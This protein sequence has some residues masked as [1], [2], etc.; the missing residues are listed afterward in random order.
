MSD[1]SW[2]NI[3]EIITTGQLRNL[4]VFIIITGVVNRFLILQHKIKIRSEDVTVQVK[5]LVVR[6]REEQGKTWNQ[7]S[8]DYNLPIRTARDIGGFY[9][10]LWFL[11]VSIFFGSFIWPFFCIS[12]GCFVSKIL[13]RCVKGQ[14]NSKWFID[15]FYCLP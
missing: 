6:A 11:Y 3:Y 15:N 9:F 2:W 1:L 14:T 4:K 10:I 8:I 13:L 5:K 7:I 12:Q